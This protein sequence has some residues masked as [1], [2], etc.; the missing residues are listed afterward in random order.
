MRA[1]QRQQVIA[2]LQVTTRM[3]GVVQRCV[4]PPTKCGRTCMRDVG[5]SCTNELRH[6]LHLM[7]VYLRNMIHLDTRGF[8]YA[9][10]HAHCQHAPCVGVHAMTP[11]HSRRG[12]R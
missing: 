9:H 10:A 7:S 4:L 3:W 2:W 8:N 5:G 6:V 1:R 12:V 11:S